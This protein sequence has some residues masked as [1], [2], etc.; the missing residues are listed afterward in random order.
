VYYVWPSFYSSIERQQLCEQLPDVRSNN[1][2]VL[3]FIPLDVRRTQVDADIYHVDD[4][5]AAAD[6]SGAPRI[7][8]SRS[9]NKYRWCA[10]LVQHA[11]DT[12]APGEPGMLL[13]GVDT[14]RSHA[15]L[16]AAGM[17]SLSAPEESPGRRR[18][19]RGTCYV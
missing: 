18:S 12:R 13:A 17:R 7:R 5:D 3:R 6:V 14:G 19:T 9:S 10:S 2:L 16:A 4:I 1:M 11:H 15:A 8:R